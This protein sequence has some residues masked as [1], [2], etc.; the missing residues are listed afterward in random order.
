MLRN[1]SWNIINI[2]ALNICF[3]LQGVISLLARPILFFIRFSDDRLD[4]FSMK[5]K[6]IQ[7]KVHIL[8]LKFACTYS[9]NSFASHHGL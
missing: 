2:S 6:Y 7:K 8:S 3:L 5:Y 9:I 4:L 1:I